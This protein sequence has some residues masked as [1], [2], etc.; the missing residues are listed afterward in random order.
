MHLLLSDV[1]DI[2]I[3][4]HEEEEEEEL[5][6]S[7]KNKQFLLSHLSSIMLI[8]RPASHLDCGGGQ[9]EAS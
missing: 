8:L 2:D 3:N 6:C 9:S 4:S 1:F 5:I 7:L